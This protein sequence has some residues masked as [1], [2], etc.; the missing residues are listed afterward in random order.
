MNYL[1]DT[2]TLLWMLIATNKLSQKV[3]AILLEPVSIKY[4]STVSLWEISLKYRLG[5]I[6]IM[7]KKPDEIPGAVGSLGI[8]FLNLDPI[9]TSTFY[10]LPKVKNKDPFDRMIAWQAIKENFIL[11]SKDKDLDQYQSSGLVRVW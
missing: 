9:T 3:R 10:Q 1:L 5:K 7:G 11:L 8:N 2:H 4:V 6:K